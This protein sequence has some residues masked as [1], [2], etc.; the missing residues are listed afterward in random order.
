MVVIASISK[1]SY[2]EPAADEKSEAYKAGYH[3]ISDIAR[4]RINRAGEK[5][6]TDYADKLAE[7][8]TPLDARHRTYKPQRHQLP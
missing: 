6:K 8:D 5:I 4:E 3:K 2:P 1:C 7:R